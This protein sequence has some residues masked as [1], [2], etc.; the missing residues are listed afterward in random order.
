MKVLVLVLVFAAA[1]CRLGFDQD[2][3]SMMMATAPDA[4][5][6]PPGDAG[7]CEPTACEAAGGTC[8]AGACERVA[9]G[10]ARLQ[11]APGMPCRLVCSGYRACRDGAS[12]E[13]A[14]WCE[15]QCIGERACQDGVACGDA[16]CEITCDG[17][18]ACEYGITLG[19][20]TCTAH[21]CGDAETC[22]GPNPCTTDG[23]CS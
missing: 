10:E 20:G 15:V 1:G 13:G 9:T 6:V 8:V 2:D 5:T 4:R 17:A 3:D 16:Q 22:S 7:A 23:I 11:C 21:C 12:C 19:A 18:E 14:P